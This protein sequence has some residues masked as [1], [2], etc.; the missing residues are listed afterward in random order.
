[1][2]KALRRTV[3]TKLILPVSS[4]RRKGQ[5]SEENEYLRDRKRRKRKGY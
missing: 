3:S 1:M 5:N 2:N 4:F